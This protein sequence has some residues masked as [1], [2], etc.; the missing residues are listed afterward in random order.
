MK[1]LIISFFFL[2]S[3]TIFFS[4]N[5]DKSPSTKALIQ[6]ESLL[7]KR[8]DSALYLSKKINRSILNNS[9]KAQYAL[10]MTKVMIKN[11]IPVKSDSL[12]NIAVEYY[13]NKGDIAHK[14]EV[15][16]YAGRVNLDMK[17]KKDALYFF[18]RASDLS[19]NS[20]DYKLRYL[21]FYYLGDL[22]YG[23]NLYSDALREQKMALY[24]SK[25]LKDSLY[26]TYALRSIAF[27]Y[28]GNNKNDA[29]LD[30]YL[31]ALHTLPKSNASYLIAFYNEISNI[32][33]CKGDFHLALKYAQK[34]IF[35]KPEGAD[36]L[37]SYVAK[38]HAL[39]GVEKYDSAVYYFSKTV[40]S[41]NLYTKTFSYV[42]L[43]RSYAALGDHKK[44]FDLMV[45]YNKYR[46]SIEAQTKGAAIIEMQ[47][48]YQHG[49][50]KEK[51]Q[52]LTFEKQEQTI[53]YYQVSFFS[54]IALLFLGG[55][56][57][58]YRSRNKKELFEKSKMLLEQE[59]K[60]IKMREKDRSLRKE[61]FR[62]L[63]KMKKIPSLSFDEDND[64][65]ET[66]KSAK[67]SLTE[68]DW[69]ELIRNIDLAYDHFTQR[70]KNTYPKLTIQE[71]HICC[72]IKIKVTKNDL[73][74]IF[75]ITPQSVKM[76][77][78]RIKKD[79]MGIGDKDITLDAILERF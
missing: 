20:S 12:I 30:Y 56:F 69:E 34:A 36:L 6:V 23:D 14:A 70:L 45:I 78:Y 64:N 27:S 76:A 60:L 50:S 66:D 41:S 26:I 52:Q 55:T 24:Y 72:L 1:N 42:M 74:N 7:D 71:I 49:K 13:N 21:I 75:C 25:L 67:I 15:N 68:K 77:K 18:L 5:L 39:F 43:S 44:A 11:D 4:C 29:G 38:G 33:C 40:C 61:F 47:N 28:A 16:Y 19:E 79:K 10:I 3:I 59:N 17:N 53:R 63:N 54:F 73:A 37:Y 32:C 58:V 22:Y 48:I 2:L 65:K 35:L 31:K 46:D 51:I 62:K 9:E 8:P 57:F